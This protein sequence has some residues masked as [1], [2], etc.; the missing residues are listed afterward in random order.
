MF[1]FTEYS[2]GLI[3][4]CLG[5]RGGECGYF[6]SSTSGAQIDK[7]CMLVVDGISWT[8]FDGFFFERRRTRMH[9]KHLTDKNDLIQFKYHFHFS[10]RIKFTNNDIYILSTVLLKSNTW[11]LRVCSTREI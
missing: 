2:W 6:G 7:I 1:P 5:G 10:V 8:C 4:L 9:I 3:V 11:L